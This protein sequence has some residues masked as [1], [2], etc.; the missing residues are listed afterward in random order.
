M[1]RKPN[2]SAISRTDTLCSF[3]MTVESN[4]ANAN[5]PVFQAK[6]SKAKT[7]YVL[8]ARFFLQFKHGT[9]NYCE[10]WLVNCA[11]YSCWDWSI[12]SITFVLVFRQS[13][14][15][16]STQSHAD[17]WDHVLD[18][19]PQATSPPQLNPLRKFVQRCV[20]DVHAGT[21]STELNPWPRLRCLNRII[22][23]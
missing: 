5:A 18:S 3:Q 7:N 14:G 9:G 12:K 11:I 13:L 2:K 20:F 19:S 4:Y 15:N 22:Y 8:Y 23:R 16:G 21:F 17:V 6:R 10:F 1:Q